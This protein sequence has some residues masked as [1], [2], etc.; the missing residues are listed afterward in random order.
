MGIAASAAAMIILQAGDRRTCTPSTRFL[1]HEPS[2]WTFYKSETLSNLVDEAQEMKAITNQIAK[3]MSE[4]TGHSIEELMNLI[5]RKEVWMSA[6]EA[7]KW[8]IIDK[9]DK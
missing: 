5:S 3:I 7:L 9:I 1:L 4:K 6:E 8:G 2:R